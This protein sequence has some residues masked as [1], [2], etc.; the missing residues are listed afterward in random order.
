[1]QALRDCFAYMAQDVND[2]LESLRYHYGEHEE[3]AEEA[4]S[5]AQ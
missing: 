4:I 3:A 2:I 5:N 1:M